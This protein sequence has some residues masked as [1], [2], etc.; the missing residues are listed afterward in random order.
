[1]CFFNV[2]FILFVEEENKK[3]VKLKKEGWWYNVSD[4]KN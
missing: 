2:N 3:D 1:M 4:I